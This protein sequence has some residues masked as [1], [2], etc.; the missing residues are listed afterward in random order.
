MYEVR[1]MYFRFDH[2]HL[3]FLSDIG[4][5]YLWKRPPWVHPTKS[6]HTTLFYSAISRISGLFTTCYNIAYFRWISPI[7]VANMTSCLL[8]SRDV[9]A[10]KSMLSCREFI[11]AQ[12]HKKCLSRLK[13]Y[14]AK[15]AQGYFPEVQHGLNDD[16]PPSIDANTL[17]SNYYRYVIKRL[18]RFSC[19]INR[20]NY[21]VSRGKLFCIRSTCR[22]NVRKTR[23]GRFC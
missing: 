13:S 2:R 8:R 10:M 18:P 23:F 12:S 5:C 19:V 16:A 15:S 7:K 20:Y 22:T 14:T 4:V 11:C 3:E 6:W 17:I 1:Y 9:K 21:I